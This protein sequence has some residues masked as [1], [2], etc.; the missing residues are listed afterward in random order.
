VKNVECQY[1]LIIQSQYN[2]KVS[3]V[4][5]FWKVIKNDRNPYN[6]MGIEG[7]TVDFVSTAIEV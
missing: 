5:T 3:Y 6:V 2:L 4:K 7:K 1:T